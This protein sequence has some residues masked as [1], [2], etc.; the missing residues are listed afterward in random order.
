MTSRGTFQKYFTHAELGD[1][2]REVLGRDPVSVQPGVY[3]VFRNDEDEQDFL[4]Q[5]QRTRFPWRRPAMPRPERVRAE[6]PPR[7]IRERVP[8]TTGRGPARVDRWQ[9]HGDL[10]DRFWQCCL[11][12]GRIPLEKEWPEI[13]RVARDVARPER[14]LEH[15]LGVHGQ[16]PFQ[17]AQQHRMDDLRV[18]LALQLFERR[19]SFG[20]LSER[21]QRD[22]RAFWSSH[23]RALDDAKTFLFSLGSPDIVAAAC[24]AAHANGI[25]WP[26]LDS[27]G[28]VDSLLLQAHL[29]SELPPSLRLY[30][31]CAGRLYG[32][33]ESADALKIHARSGKLSAMLY[34]DFAGLA[35]PNLIER[36]KIDLRRQSI[37]VFGYGSAEFPPQPLWLKA[38]L[39][40]PEQDEYE[41]QKAFD[42]ALITSGLFD[43]SG[44]GPAREVVDVGLAATGRRIEGWS[45]V[46]VDSGAS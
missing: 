33:L 42:D 29:L 5:R 11:A 1:Y 4:E 12:F 45:I 8:R 38:R 40:V 10:L 35:V 9:A 36:V 31:G 19:Q 26:E 23:G 16:E 15:L 6:R 44:F 25:G 27:A 46:K 41:R 32:D 18:Y 17:A 22:I 39:L 7:P 24:E 13:E 30:V 14:A 43:F 3:F 2:I 21:V 37:D 28:R 34:D 20:H